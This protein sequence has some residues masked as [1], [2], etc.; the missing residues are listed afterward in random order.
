MPNDILQVGPLQRGRI[1][2]CPSMECALTILSTSR[3]LL[4]NSP[5]AQ[6]GSPRGPKKRAT[7]ARAVAN[8]LPCRIACGSLGETCLPKALWDQREKV[9]AGVGFEPTTFRL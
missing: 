4:S 5:F 3:R 1:T 8:W 7:L 9:V 6:P 2:R